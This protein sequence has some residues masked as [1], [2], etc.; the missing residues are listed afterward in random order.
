[1]STEKIRARVALVIDEEQIAINAGSDD[2]VQVND[3]LHILRETHIPDPD[4]PNESLGIAFVRKGTLVVDSVQEKFSVA[5]VLRQSKTLLAPS[6]PT[7]RIVH[8][9]PQEGRE[10]V[11]IEVGDPVDV[12]VDG[13]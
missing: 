11:F 7:F 8:S 1:M 6:E 2:G 13:S 12:L 5:R 3:R 4:D 9:A 10:R